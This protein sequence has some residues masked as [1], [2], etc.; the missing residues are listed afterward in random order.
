MHL[1]NSARILGIIPTP[2]YSHQVVFQPLWKEL[3]L[4]GHQV[5]VLTTNPIKDSTLTNLTEIDTS[6][7]YKILQD[8]LLEIIDTGNVFKVI[9]LSINIFSV[10]FDKQLEHPQVKQLINDPNLQFDLVIFEYIINMPLAF[11]MKFNC[12]SIGVLFMNAPNIIH[13]ILG[14]PTHPVLYPFFLLNKNE[15]LTLTER[16]ASV[17]YE[18]VLDIYIDWISLPFQESIL[19]KHFGQNYNLIESRKNVSL[20]FVNSDPIFDVIRPTTPILVPIGGN[21]MRLPSKPLQKDIHKLLDNAQEGF[22]YFSLGSNVNSKDMPQKTMNVILKTF[23][24]LPYTILW[25]Y[26][27]EELPN[28]PRNVIISKWLPQLEVLKHKNLKLFITH[29]GAL[30]IEE[31]ISARVPILGM[32]FFVD[33][34]FNVDKMVNLGCA[35]SVNYKNLEKEQFTSAILEMINNPAY[36]KRIKELADLAE[37]QPMTGLERA[38]WWTEYVLRHNGTRHFQNPIFDIPCARI[39]GIIPT[40]SYSHQVIYQPL[41]KELSLRG[42][43]VTVLTTNPIK[44]ATLTNLTEIDTS[45]SYKILQDKLLEIIE[46]G[47][48][49]KVINLAVNIFSLVF[50]KQLEH[51]QVK[52]LINDPNL[53]FDIVIF[54][55]I[56]S[57]P[58]AFAMK[59]NCPSIGV[60]FM[61]APNILHKSLGHPTHPVLYPFYLLNKNEKLTLIERV[62]SV[63][64]DFAL[65]MYI[66]WVSLPLQETILQK[67]FGQNYNLMESS[68]NVSLVFVNSDPIFDVIRP[69]TPMLVP[70]GGDLMRLPSKLLQK[71][72]QKLLDNAQEGFIYFSLGSNVNSK[73]MPQKTMNVILKT[74][75]ELPYTILWKYELEELPNKPNNVIISKWLPQLEVLKHKNLKLFITH[76]GALS[77][78]ESISARV[79]ILGMPFFVDQPFHVNKMVNLGCALSVNYKN[80]EKEQFTSAILE[81]INNPA[82]RKRI[83]ELAD[84]AEDQPMTGLERA[85]W[86]TEYVLRHN[87]T[88]HFKNPIFDIPCARILG[89]IPTPSY[90]H[91][92]IFQPLWKE[93]SLRGHQVTVLTTNPIK[94]S[95][96]T[97]LTEIDTSFSYKILQDKLLEIIDTR[98]VFKV[99]D[100]SLKIFSIVFDKQLEH[101]Q[102]KQLI[103]DSNMQFDLVIFEYVTNMPMAFAMKFSCP[104]IGVASIEVPNIL[105]KL[106]GHPTH[107]ILYPFFLLNKSDKLTLSERVI[108]VVYEFVLELYVDWISLPFQQSIVQKHFGQHYNLM[109]IINNVSLV[110]INSNPI[111]DVIRPTTPILVPIGGNLMR[112]PSKPLQEDM[113][114]LLENAEGGF[115]YFSLGSNVNSKDIPQKTM[116]VILKTFEELPYTILWKYESEELPNKPNNVII[117]KWLPQLE[118]LKHKNLKLFITHGG[119]QSIEESISARVPILGM[120]FFVDQLFNVDKMV[121]LGCALSVNHKNLEKEQFTSAILEMINNPAYRKRIKE[122]AD[123]AED[124]PMTGLERAVWWTEYV[125][126]HNGTR[127]FK[128]PIFD[129]PCHQAVF[130]PF[131][132]ELSL[133]GHQVTV[134]T[135]HPI[136]DATLTNLTEIDTSFSFKLLTDNL[137]DVLNNSGNALKVIDLSVKLFCNVFDKQLELPQVKRF[138]NDPS[139]QFDL[140]IFEYTL[141]VPV[142]FTKKFNCPS[143]AL[144]PTDIPNI[145]HKSLGH[146]THPVLYPDSILD[147]SNLTLMKRV[148]AVLYDFIFELYIEWSFMPYQESIMQKHFG[149]NYKVNEIEKSISLVFVHSDPIFYSIRPIT[150]MMIP[151][152]GQLMRLPPKPLEKNIKQ[153]LDN[154][155]EGFI[156]FSLGSNIDGKDMPEKTLKVILETFKELP[157]TVLWKYELDLPNKPDNVVTSKWLSQLEVLKHP[158]IKLF[159]THGG[160]QSVDEAVSARVPILG[161]PFC[162]DQPFTVNRMVTRGAALS[163]DYKTLEKENFKAIILEMINNPAYRKRITE[164]ADLAEDQP[165]TGLE[166]AVWWTEYVLRHNGTKHLKNPIFDMPCHQAVFQ[167]FWKE[168]S[169]RGH[170]GTVL[171]SHPINGATLT[172]LTDID[173]SFLFKLLTDNLID[174][175]NNS[176]NTLKVIDLSTNLFCNVFDKQL[177]LPQIKRFINDPNVQFDLVIFEYLLSVRKVSSKKFN[178]P[179]IGVLQMDSPNILHKSLAHPEHP[180]LYPNII[181]DSSNLTLMKRVNA[182]LS[183]IFELYIKW[184]FMPYQE[185]IIQKHFGNNYSF[186]DI[187]KSVSLVFINS[188]P[189]FYPIKPITPMIIPIGGQLMR[190]PPKPLEKDI[191]QKLDNAQVGFIYFSF[192]SNIDSKDMPEKTL[193][194]ILE[195]LKELPC[196]VLWNYEL[197]LPNK[198]DNVVTSKWVLSNF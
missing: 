176:G 60:L 94:D 175:L 76:G 54:E 150:P 55:Y 182:I 153:K 19:Q 18:F 171:T 174:V 116:N 126:R 154:A 129:I 41:W 88:R 61:N 46:T 68:K 109:K 36:R 80:L 83:T 198:P 97:N 112:L 62:A 121:K 131:W 137:V 111:F 194:M 3:S 81:M 186:K 157:Y 179:S 105:H 85:V 84:L 67:H 192:G 48:P 143:I 89:I 118:V 69:I 87:G 7:S 23:E 90:S 195:T 136:N 168:L 79:P 13:K 30:S 196:T 103:N 127:H 159:I 27:L 28:K 133:R 86:W 11:A 101:P 65:E 26:E 161:M 59:F 149:S 57:M 139:V 100:L 21:L 6:F 130:Q 146:P 108:A 106:L 166:R 8:K 15:K 10:V 17:V 43:Q 156:Y 145:I 191:K 147:S 51:P 115:I 155:Q 167:P 165:M 14:H 96:L 34:P 160:G 189:V 144:L 49:F 77:I 50:D 117:S 180:V 177:E 9:D 99:I 25:K 66:E 138:I 187:E 64:Y 134:L 124:Q 1:C 183:D 123:L 184:S 42:H 162:T 102:V 74:F 164:L 107:P 22:I 140:V 173:I 12:P 39:L 78:E 44:D 122:L 70:I 119:A 181:L 73:D 2:S 190:L 52:Q 151:I 98:N 38:V 197:D 114:K 132:K 72:I 33:Q 170:Q 45:F 193:K 188:D 53:Q 95:T 82:Y 185:S 104:L 163:V 35:L 16:V 20:L 135:S 63:V 142:A 32:P 125:L 47:N 71:D 141:S 120:P 5:T 92:V 113:Q 4:R 56:M 75:E 40:P 58:L 91:Q 37:D 169:L 93:L 29:G 31:S 158:N 148:I 178:C 128:N 172:N 152:G 110:F 24:E